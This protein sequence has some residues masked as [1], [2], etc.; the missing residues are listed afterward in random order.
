MSDKSDKKEFFETASATTDSDNSKSGP[1]AY[2][3]TGIAVA[4]I[5]IVAAVSSSCASL[6][7]AGI[8]SQEKASGGY[9]LNDPTGEFP[10]DGENSDLDKLLEQYYDEMEDLTGTQGTGTTGTNSP[11]N[12]SGSYAT[13]A[14]ALGFDLTVYGT[15]ID[16][17][18]SANAYAGVPAEVHDFVRTLVDKDEDYTKQVTDT[19]YAALN[20]EGARAAKVKEAIEL[21]KKASQEFSGMTVPEVKGATDG[22]VKDVLGDAL[23]ST[24]DRWNSLER[25]LAILDTTEDKIQ[26][27]KLWN[28]DDDVLEATEDAADLLEEGMEASAHR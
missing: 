14:E 19:L 26:T 24:M 9:T 5:L 12:Q 15:T 11:N 25:E 22:N 20:D 13:V 6:F 18:V 1:F 10:F 21:C 8:A 28:L 16:D 2:I 23:S 4:L 17:M 7:A 3:V 27:K